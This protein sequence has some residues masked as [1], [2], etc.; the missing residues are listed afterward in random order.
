VVAGLAQQKRP[1]P[2]G[3]AGRPNT[4]A[5]ILDL[6]T[7]NARLRRDNE[8]LHMERGIKKNA[9]HL[10]RATEMKFRFIEDQRE[11]FPVRVMCDVMGVSPA[12]Y[13]AWRSRPESLRK[14]PIAPRSPRS[15]ASMWAIAAAM[16]LRGST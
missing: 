13:Y 12:G 4:Q 2:G 1:E 16:A 7:E 3:V 8:R 9:A 6:A 10:L 15:G 14:V 5:A 11:A